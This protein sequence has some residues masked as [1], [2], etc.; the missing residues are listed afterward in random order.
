MS[1]TP[2]I[3]SRISGNVGMLGAGYPGYFEPRDE[4]GL[5]ACLV[6]ALEDSGYRR[7]LERACRER[8]PLFAPA[9]EA[10]ALRELVQILTA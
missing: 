9:A 2:A 4:S 10:R 1:G 3:A 6:Q 8:K 7:A 5:A